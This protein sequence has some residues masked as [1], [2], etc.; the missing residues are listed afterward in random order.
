MTAAPWPPLCAGASLRGLGLEPLQ[1]QSRW[2]GAGASA[3]G[4]LRRLM[5]SLRPTPRRSLPILPK[6]ASSGTGQAGSALQSCRPA[7]VRQQLASRVGPAADQQP[8]GGQAR[9]AHHSRREPLHRPFRLL[10]SCRLRRL[11]VAWLA[12]R[13][14]PGA[15]STASPA[16]RQQQ[17]HRSAG[18]LRPS[19]AP[20]RSPTTP[21]RARV[22]FRRRSGAGLC[23]RGPQGRCA[24]LGSRLRSR[25]RA[26]R[27][28]TLPRS[29][30]SR[31]RAEAQQAT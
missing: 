18:W 8:K 9:L 7:P 11:A 21:S 25:P 30:R 2:S 29:P 13:G 15:S 17:G 22:H 10:P 14:P 26:G 23:A 31:L 1:R 24:E 3:A 20:C 16:R 12:G 4:S 5:L 28:R 27:C 19:A 6:G